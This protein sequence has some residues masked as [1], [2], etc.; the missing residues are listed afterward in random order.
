MKEGKMI[1]GLDEDVQN[2]LSQYEKDNLKTTLVYFLM[3]LD[4]Y[5]FGLARY[6]A[7]EG[8]DVLFM[9]QPVMAVDDFVANFEQY[10]NHVNSQSVVEQPERDPGQDVVDQI[11]KMLASA[12]E[13]I[14]N[15]QDDLKKESE[16]SEVI[17]EAQ[18]ILKS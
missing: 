1:E 17:E 3:F 13:E 7:K 11:M 6:P 5:G 2:G 12:T 8:E 18:E 10:V 16:T 9:A 14:S 4:Q 15:L